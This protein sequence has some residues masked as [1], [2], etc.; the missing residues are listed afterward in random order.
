MIWQTCYPRDSKSF[1]PRSR[2]NQKL[3]MPFNKLPWPKISNWQLQGKD[4]QLNEGYILSTPNKCIFSHCKVS[5]TT[6]KWR[7][8]ELNHATRRRKKDYKK[9]TPIENSQRW[10]GK[11]TFPILLLN[12]DNMI[13]EHLKTRMKCQICVLLRKK[14]KK[15]R[16]KYLLK[17]CSLDIFFVSE[18]KV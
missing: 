10:I 15:E 12:D 5:Q 8:I 2:K 6:K 3:S 9:G 11:N 4:T 14:K 13:G 16:S 17:S 1:Y 7:E 18:K